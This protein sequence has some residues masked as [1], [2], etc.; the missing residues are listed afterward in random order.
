MDKA[1]QLARSLV[2]RLALNPNLTISEAKEQLLGDI[3]NDRAY[4]EIWKHSSK[5][6]QDLLKEI[7]RGAEAIF[8][9]KQRIIFAR[10]LV[11]LSCQYL[12]YNHQFEFFKERV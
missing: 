7:A 6:E 1:P 8:S 9:E 10:N 2:E 5:L 12:R 4:V 3:F 11:Y